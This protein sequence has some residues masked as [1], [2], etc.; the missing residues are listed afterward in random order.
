MHFLLSTSPRTISVPP[1][2][3]YNRPPH[4]NIA[5]PTAPPTIHNTSLPQPPVLAATAVC[6]LP[7]PAV[8]VPD[9]D[10]T[11]AVPL[12]VGAADPAPATTVIAVTVDLEPSGRVVVCSIVLVYEDCAPRLVVRR[13]ESVADPEAPLESEAGAIV[14]TPPPTVVT[15]VT[16]SALVVVITVPEIVT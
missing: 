15:M 8:A 14:L 7:L 16:P 4:I 6:K 12:G 3:L 2:S 1:R 11:P 9:P 10:E 13:V 5:T